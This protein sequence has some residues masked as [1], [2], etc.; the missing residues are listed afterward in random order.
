MRH[1][2]RLEERHDE[3]GRAQHDETHERR[4]RVAQEDTLGQQ[5]EGEHRSGAGSTRRMAAGG[6]R[7]ASTL[8]ATVPRPYPTNATLTQPGLNPDTVLSI[9]A[10]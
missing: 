5:D 2:P 9:G 1:E 6:T 4:R 7:P 3:R 10:T 8:P